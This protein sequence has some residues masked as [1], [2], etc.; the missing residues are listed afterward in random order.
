MSLG[1]VLVAQGMLTFFGPAGWFNKTLHLLHLTN[2]PL[3]LVHNRT[4]VVIS[5]IITEFPVTFLILLSFAS[6]I[7]PDLER[8]ARVLGA[9][10]W[11]RF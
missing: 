10:T 7:D 3:Q 5:L 4:G 8:V 2:E 1:T 6:G 11:Q 9:G